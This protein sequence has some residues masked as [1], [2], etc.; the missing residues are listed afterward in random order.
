M[1]LNDNPTCR[2][3][4]TEEETSAHTLCECEALASH[5]HTYLG[6][7]FFWSRR[8]LGCWVWGPSGNL[9]KEQG[10]YNLVQ[11]WEHRGPVLKP[12]CIG[13]GEGPY[14]IY[15]STL[16]AWY[17]TILSAL[18]LQLQDVLGAFANLRKATFRFI[19]SFCPSAR[20]KPRLPMDGFSR[21]L[22]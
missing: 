11:Y 13:P 14:P 8:T 10:S 1:G 5:R 12:R 15:H 17:R 3:C 16:K 22:I 20:K 18:L 7:F 6:S 4:G 2:K 21:N 9:L 19:R